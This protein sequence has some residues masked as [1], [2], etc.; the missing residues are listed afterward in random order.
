MARAPSSAFPP[1]P[2]GPGLRGNVGWLAALAVGVGACTADVT[3]PDPNAAVTC[4]VADAVVLPVGGTQQARGGGGAELCI[5]APAEG[6]EYVLVTYSGEVP[7]TNLTRLRFLAEGVGPAAGPP[8]PVAPIPGAD[9]LDLHGHGFLRDGAFDAELR[10]RERTEL[11]GRVGPG[12]D[13]SP[14]Q[15]PG[16]APAGVPAVGSLL[17]LNAQP[18]SACENP[19]PRGA[20]V[21]AVSQRAIVV[22]D[23]LNPSGGFTSDD[24]AHFAAVF[25]TLVVPVMDT[26]FGE[27]TDL[28]GNGRTILFFTREVNRLTEE[29]S[30]RFVG[31]FFYARDLFPRTGTSR[32]Q[33]CP[34]SNHA[35]ILYLMVPEPGRNP[36]NV[37]GRAAVRRNTPSTLAH[38]QQHLVNA[39]RRLHILQSP[40]AFE[41][42]WLNEGLSHTAEE[43]LFYRASGLQ[44]RSNLGLADLQAGGSRVLDAVNAHHL[45]NILRFERYLRDPSAHSPFDEEDTLEA[46]GA[47]HQF[48]RYAADRRGGN[49][50]GFLRAL[51]DASNGGVANLADRLG[52]EEVLHDWLA[53]WTVAAYADARVPGLEARHRLLSWSHP[54]L[55]QQLRI[56]P[57]PIRTR[58]LSPDTPLEVEL[59]GGGAAHLRFGVSGG[60]G[61]VIRISQGQTHPSPSIRFT[62]LRTR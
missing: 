36:D 44:P 62:L 47:A 23:T 46:R 27:P 29:G 41:D 5:R 33:A 53:D 51:V 3:G 58:P 52:G 61:A 49:D 57:Y 56:Q 54:S 35:E 60:E 37:W 40:T 28:D 15:V 12:G 32:L 24:Y 20:R 38:E 55:F 9:A 16:F 1:L 42:T 26:H 30:E 6:G 4:N 25:D 50:A 34:T 17:T 13:G 2:A 43:L 14:A 45:S 21:M 8:A 10:A 22:A 48:L 11:A 7:S 39:A 31:G 59:V 19:M 18:R